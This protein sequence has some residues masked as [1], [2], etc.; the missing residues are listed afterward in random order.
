[1]GG[2]WTAVAD[3][4]TGAV[5]GTWTLRRKRSFGP[6]R[7]HGIDK[8]SFKGETNGFES[9]DDFKYCGKEPGDIIEFTEADIHG[10]VH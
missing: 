2:T 5:T 8:E 10:V 9:I 1:M 3:A 6:A 7:C 4:K